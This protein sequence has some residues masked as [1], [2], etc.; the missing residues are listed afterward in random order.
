MLARH[1][2]AWQFQDGRIVLHGVELGEPGPEIETIL[3]PF[4]DERREVFELLG[5]PGAEALSDPALELVEQ[6]HELHADMAMLKDEN[7]RLRELVANREE[8]L[9]MNMLREENAS[10]KERLDHM[11]CAL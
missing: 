11:K 1:A 3:K 2:L 8:R 5:H 10:L 4:C 6:M 9:E 7:A